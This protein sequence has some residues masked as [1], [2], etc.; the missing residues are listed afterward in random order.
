ML[1][2]RT[3]TASLAEVGLANPIVSALDSGSGYPTG[4]P[5]SVAL[6]NGTLTAAAVLVPPSLVV[7]LLS[8]SLPQA[9]STT[10]TES[11]TSAINHLFI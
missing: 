4:S 8:E 2:S 1:C 6:S 7:E 10:L 5:L 11:T 9:P 3:W